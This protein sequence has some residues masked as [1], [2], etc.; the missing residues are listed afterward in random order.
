MF[1]KKRKLAEL[2]RRMTMLR[3]DLTYLER[4]LAGKQGE[5]QEVSE[6]IKDLVGL[7]EYKQKK[8]ERISESI[9]EIEKQ[10]SEAQLS[11]EVLTHFGV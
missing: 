3:E 7:I 8:Q 4:R 11:L 9:A 10:K 2:E 1:W 5:L 6:S